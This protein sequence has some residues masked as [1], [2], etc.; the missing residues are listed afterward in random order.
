[1]ATLVH[2]ANA[3]SLRQLAYVVSL[4]ETLNFTR[5]AERC[6]VTQSTLSA[7]IRE[8]EQTLGVVLFER[9]RQSVKVTPMG[10]DLIERARSLLS[11]ALDLVNA[12][13]EAGRPLQGTVT[14]G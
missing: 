5:A 4:S 14:L 3:L 9:D 8:L 6:F 1:M 2:A 11:Q 7:G 12:A 13:Q 10:R